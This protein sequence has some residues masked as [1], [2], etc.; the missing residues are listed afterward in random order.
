ME[1]GGNGPRLEA[2]SII[3]PALPALPALPDRPSLD[4][5]EAKWGARW[6]ALLTCAGAHVSRRRYSPA[7]ALAEY[8]A[9]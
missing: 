2:S 6:E 8:L 9:D 7:V 3:P 1:A 5:L 4:G